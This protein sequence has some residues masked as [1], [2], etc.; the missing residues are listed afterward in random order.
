V[1]LDESPAA[2]AILLATLTCPLLMLIPVTLTFE[3]GSRLVIDEFK[4]VPVITYPR[5]APRRWP[6]GPAHSRSPGGSLVR[7]S[8]A[9]SK[10]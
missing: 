8:H 10:L 5:N 1:I 7:S 6:A 3:P 2:T 9:R 4:Q